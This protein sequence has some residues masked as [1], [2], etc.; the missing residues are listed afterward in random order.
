MGVQQDAGRPELM[1]P[2]QHGHYFSFLFLH[3]CIRHGAAPL[4]PGLKG[5]V[6]YISFC[7][8]WSACAFATTSISPPLLG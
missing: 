7:C 6:S 8:K 4:R 5:H 3:I 2:T 1:L